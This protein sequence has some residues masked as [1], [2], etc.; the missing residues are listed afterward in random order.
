MVPRELIYPPDQTEEQIDKQNART[1]PTSQSSAETAALSKLGYPLQIAVK[2]VAAGLAGRRASCK[3]G[4]VIISVDGAQGDSAD[5]L[6]ELIR[7]KPAGTTFTFGITRAGAADDGR[8]SPTAAGDDGVPRIGVAPGDASRP[9]PFTVDIPIENIGG[10]S[11]GLML[12]PRHHRQ[13]QAGGPHRREDHRR[14]GHHRRRRQGRPDR[15]HA[16]E[17]GRGQGGRGEVLPDPG[18]QLRR[19]GRQRAAG[20]AVGQGR[21]ASTRRWP[22]WTTS[23]PA[24]PTAVRGRQTLS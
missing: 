16:A 24:E 1:S 11:A 22:R 9:R 5:K 8:R 10:P 4:D 7:A 23:G 19:G 17:A 18:G 12:D 13:G 3:P 20:A 6:L 14:H 15:R 2:E 21:H